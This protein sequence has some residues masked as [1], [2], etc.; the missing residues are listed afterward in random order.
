MFRVF[1]GVLLVVIGIVLGVIILA[2]S[3]DEADN[4]EA[5]TEQPATSTTEA[6]AATPDEDTTPT[7]LIAQPEVPV[8]TPAT[9]P[10]TVPQPVVRDPAQV[11]VQV[12]NA[13]DVAGAAGR[14][15]TTLTVAGYIGLPAINAPDELQP[16]SQSL[17][18]YEPD[19]LGDANQIAALVGASLSSVLPLPVPSPITSDGAHVIVVIGD[20]GLAQ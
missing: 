9:T 3:L 6:A 17:I 14:L 13:T 4:A 7:T 8:T 19:Y 1:R 15:T 18:Y 10:E 12:A 2:S 11:R 20:D 5:D 16:L